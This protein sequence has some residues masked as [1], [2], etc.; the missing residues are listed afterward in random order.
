[1]TR[2]PRR[3]ALAAL[4]LA[5]LAG[6]SPLDQPVATLGNRVITLDDVARAARGNEAQYPLNP[7][8]AK[9][10]VVKDLVVREAMLAA[11]HDLGYA[12]SPAAAQFRAATLAQAMQR[13]LQQQ[14]APPRVG[15]TEAEIA[16]LYDWRGVRARAQVVYVLDERSAREAHAQLIAGV[17]FEQVADRWN[18]PGMLGPGGEAGWLTPGQLVQPL[19][20]AL[21]L[22]AEGELGGPYRTPQGWFLLRVNERRAEEQMELAL[23]RA[24]L[25]Q[26]LRQRKQRATF[27]RAVDDLKAAYGVRLAFAAPQRIFQM[28]N[29]PDAAPMDDAEPLATWRG[30]RYTFADLRADLD[31]PDVDKPPA[32][33]LPAIEVWLEA[34]AMTRVLEQE[35]RRRHLHELPSVRREVEDQFENYL[36]QSLYAEVTARTPPAPEDAVRLAY[37]RVKDNFV[38]LDQVSVQWIELPDSATANAIARHGAHAGSLAEAVRMHDAALVV[39]EERI[40]F[41]AA[42][43]RWALLEAAFIRMQPGEWAGPDAMDGRWRIVQLVDKVQETQSLERLPAPV[44]ENLRR[45][46]GEMARDAYFVAYADSVQRAKGVRFFD[47]PL[48][49][50]QW[51]I[52]A[53]LTTG[54]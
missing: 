17:P 16:R 11:A 24:G 44:L 34:R 36:V 18:F 1:V 39:T 30:G 8:T 37:E 20:D 25:E 33:L 42:D 19:D 12:D 49:R 10:S 48:R 9:D 51:P 26:L 6:C 7:A 31:R 41:P 53:P 28:F 13:A 43:P 46:A 52:P 38:R 4:A 45:A 5:A 15:V 29:Q 23:Q 35:A 3:A 2:Y 54:S 32:T 50:L 21:R 40:A 27:A 47:R 22:Q 14:L